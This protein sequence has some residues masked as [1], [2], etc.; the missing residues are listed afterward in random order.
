MD[1][2]KITLSDIKKF[3]KDK[4]YGFNALC[5]YN[6]LIFQ[7]NGLRVFKQ[8]IFPPAIRYGKGKFYPAIGLPEDLASEIYHIFLTKIDDPNYI[9][10]GVD[11]AVKPL[12]WTP[13]TIKKYGL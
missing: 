10:V 6:D 11:E 13:E 1:E 3:D 2:W 7:V 5:E 9:E 12:L 8:G 4:G